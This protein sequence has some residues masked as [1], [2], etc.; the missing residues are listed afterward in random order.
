MPLN[1]ASITELGQEKHCCIGTPA[2]NKYFRQQI[3]HYF[4]CVL[5]IPVMLTG[6][7]EQFTEYSRSANQWKRW[8]IGAKL[9]MMKPI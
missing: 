3:Q 4:V 6:C 7:R 2:D 1:S 9:F 8:K 5:T